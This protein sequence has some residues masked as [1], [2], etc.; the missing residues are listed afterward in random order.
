MAW[1]IVPLGLDLLDNPLFWSPET[2]RF[3]LRSYCGVRERRGLYMRDL[4][5]GWARAHDRIE[6]VPVL[7]EPEEGDD[8]NGRTGFV[9]EAA[10]KDFPTFPQNKCERAKQWSWCVPPP[11]SPPADCLHGHVFGC[12]RLRA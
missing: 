8:G 3:S 6:Y 5:D 11:H 4:V 2:C 7:S 12:F 9:H 1:L 10:M